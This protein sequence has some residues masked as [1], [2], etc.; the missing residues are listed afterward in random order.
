L[1]TSQWI[2]VRYE[3]LC[4][5][6]KKT[7]SR[8]FEFLGFDPDKRSWEFRALENHVV[9]NGMRLDATSEIRLDERWRSVLTEGDLRSFDHEAGEMNRRYGYA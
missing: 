6:T 7:L 9:G 1:D 5:D 8:L 2:E 3:E 4:R